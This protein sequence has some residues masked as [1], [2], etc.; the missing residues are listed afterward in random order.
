[1]KRKEGFYYVSWG[2][3]A[4]GLGLTIPG[5]VLVVKVRKAKRV[6]VDPSIS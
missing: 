3:M 1:M 5:V 2:L 6:I 4:A